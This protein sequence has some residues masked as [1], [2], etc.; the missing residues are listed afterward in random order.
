[1]DV[2]SI[3]DN[4]GASRCDAIIILILVATLCV[5]IRKGVQLVKDVLVEDGNGNPC[6]NGLKKGR[7]H[8]SNCLRYFYFLPRPRLLIDSPRRLNV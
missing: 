8:L 7:Y 1:M 6:A 2:A 4:G 5:A 3:A